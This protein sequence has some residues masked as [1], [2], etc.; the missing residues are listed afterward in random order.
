MATLITSCDES[1]ALAA[2]ITSTVVWREVTAGLNSARMRMHWKL[3]QS[4][5]TM[6]T[7]ALL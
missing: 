3:V 5:A 7:G 2:L 6:P 4:P 1:A